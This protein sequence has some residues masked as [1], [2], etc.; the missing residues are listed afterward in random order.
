MATYTLK[1]KVFGGPIGWAPKGVD[2]SKL[3]YAGRSN[4]SVTPGS[5][6]KLPA[7]PIHPQNI[8]SNGAMNVFNS[9]KRVGQSSVGVLGG[10]KN[11]WN[12]AGIGGKAGMGAAA[13]GG[14]YLLGKGLG[15]WGNK[16]D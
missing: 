10:L 15:L 8:P 2:T 5:S 3:T 11:T 7:A 6:P 14:T 1:Q 9:G 16:K 12:R 13:V 4:L